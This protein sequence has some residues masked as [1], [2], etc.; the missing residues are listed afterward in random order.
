MINSINENKSDKIRV[1]IADDHPI[2][3]ESIKS[4]LD[5]QQDMEII[6]EAS[7]GKEAVIL[8]DK[9]LP[10]IILMDISMPEM[11]GIDA[12]RIIKSRH[13][14]IAILVLTVQT[15]KEYIIGIL[16]AGAAGYLTKSVCS[17]EVIQAIRS[18]L[19]GESVLTPDILKEFLGY[20]SRVSIRPF[21]NNVDFSFKEIALLKLVARG[22]SN[23]R[24]A[25]EL[26]YTENTVKR[27]LTELFSKMNV[28]SRTEAVVKGFNDG[29]IDFGDLNSQG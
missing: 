9:L 7:N 11:N 4:Q 25:Q 20:A 22:M 26:H 16:E 19:A 24:I 12:T 18:T 23:K 3:R 5:E 17:T 27:Y 8:A 1:L 15:D 14:E 13:S 29:I 21:S 28:I 10:D 6:A 2:V